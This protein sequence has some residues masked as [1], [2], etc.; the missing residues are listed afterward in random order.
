MVVDVDLLGAWYRV[1]SGGGRVDV[2][3]VVSATVFVVLVVHLPPAQFGVVR[4][5]AVVRSGGVVVTFCCCCEEREATVFCPRDGGDGDVPL[6]RTVVLTS[7]GRGARVDED[8]LS[9]FEVVRE[10]VVP[11]LRGA[12]VSRGESSGRSVPLG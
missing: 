12:G 10:A 9:S 5:G 7:S 1:R 4:V 3:V 6:L 8:L 2:V 11:L